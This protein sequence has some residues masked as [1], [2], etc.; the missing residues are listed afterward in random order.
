MNKREFKEFEELLL[1]QQEEVKHSRA[2]ARKLLTKLGIMHLL[3]P[4][5]TNKL[6]SG[7]SR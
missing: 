2:A 5:G 4:K 7:S 3:V 1:Q 6:S